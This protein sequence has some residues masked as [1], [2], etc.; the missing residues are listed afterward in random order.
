MHLHCPCLAPH[1]EIENEMH[2]MFKTVIFIKLCL[3]SKF[4]SFTVRMLN[5][6]TSASECDSCNSH[7]K[8]IHDGS[9]LELV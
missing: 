7:R 4:K 9:K 3:N 2:A 8:N 1:H 6:L 5:V